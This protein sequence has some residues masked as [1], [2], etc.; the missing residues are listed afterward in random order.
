MTILRR[1]LEKSALAAVL[2]APGILGC[3]SDAADPKPSGDL[4]DDVVGTFKIEVTADESGPSKGTTAVLGRVNTGPT[5]LNVVW[6]E[7]AREGAC[8]LDKPRVPFCS[9]SCGSE[10]VCVEDNVCRPY[11][12]ALSAGTVTLE[13]VALSGGETSLTLREV[14]KSY[15]PPGGTS[16]AYPPFAEGGAVRLK[17]SGGEVPAFELETKGVAPLWLTDDAFSLS[18]D[19]PLELRWTAASN[20][21][22]SRVHVELDISHHGGS[23]GLI[24]CDGDDT[25]SLTIAASLIS[26]LIDLGV[27]G[28]PSMS[29]TRA[30][31]AQTGQVSLVVSSFTERAVSVPGLT[32][33]TTNDECPSGQTCQTDLKCQ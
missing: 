33:C 24:A 30:S 7:S 11:P 27:S 13:G 12:T 15:Q 28:F 20:S 21:S 14:S 10:A 25:G 29:M 16:F 5:P 22:A 9:P 3:S 1:S 2:I 6:E 31:T 4:G 19:S 17:A 18:P 32:S 8:R 23:K 26:Q